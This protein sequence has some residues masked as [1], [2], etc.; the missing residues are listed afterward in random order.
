MFINTRITRIDFDRFAE[1]QD[2]IL[3][4]LLVHRGESTLLISNGKIGRE[5]PVEIGRFPIH[6]DG[7]VPIV[8]GDSLFGLQSKLG[9][10]WVFFRLRELSEEDRDCADET[11]SRDRFHVWLFDSE[12][13]Q[14]IR[15]WQQE[16]FAKKRKFLMFVPA[17]TSVRC[18]S[19]AR[20][21]VLVDLGPVRPR[22]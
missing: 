11:E 19:S 15:S 17:M 22:V 1:I 8:V 10:L 18:R 12:L 6:F 2:G 9:C 20:L 7:F 16:W 13:Y 21:L 5:F 3:K 4:P 14:K